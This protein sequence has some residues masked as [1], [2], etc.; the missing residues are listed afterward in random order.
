[1]KVRIT[2][3]KLP[4]KYQ[5]ETRFPYLDKLHKRLVE[6]FAAYQPKLLKGIVSGCHGYP[7]HEMSMPAG[8]TEFEKLIKQFDKEVKSAKPKVGGF[9]EVKPTEEEAKHAR[10]LE[11]VLFAWSVDEDANGRP[12][13]SPKRVLCGACKFPDITCVPEPFLVSK[14]VTKKLEVF[15]V[16]T[17]MLVVKSRVLKLLQDAIGDQVETGEA[18]IAKSNEK[19]TGD[20]RVFWVRP[21]Q[22]IGDRLLKV[23]GDQCPKCKRLLSRGVGMNDKHVNNRGGGLVDMRDWVEHFGTTK[24]DIAVVAGYNGRIEDG[25]PRWYWPILMSGALVAYLKANKVTGIAASTSQIEPEVYFS[26]DGEPTFEPNVRT[27]GT[28]AASAEVER[29]DAVRIEA[30]RNAVAALKDVPWDCDKDG[31]VYLHLTTPEVMVLDPMTWEEDSDGPY[32]VPKFKKPGLY[33]L[34]VKAIKDAE[35]KKRGVAVD[36]ATLLFIDNSFFSELQDHYDWD[37]ATKSDGNI[38]PKYHNEIAAK[39]GSRFGVC[40]APSAKF[41]SEFAGDGLYTIDAKK[42][43]ACPV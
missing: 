12:L 28:V 10:F 1:M 20:E 37:K 27:F 22:M 38:D 26:K 11:P 15:R 7:T 40:S 21:K 29:E 33:R 43:E 14:A 41:K 9:F 42:I 3:G 4:W 30:G 13:N 5:T 23:I 17:G 25:V 8:D 39:I 32:R 36:S 35:G 31:Y 16:S 34:P 24:S 2:L 18:V 6:M 19:L